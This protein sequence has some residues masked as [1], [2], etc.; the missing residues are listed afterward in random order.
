MIEL[1]IREVA[2]SRGIENPFALQTASGLNYAVCHRLWKAQS[3]MIGI[4]TLDKLCSALDCYPSDLFVYTAQNS[5][6]SEEQA[7]IDKTNKPKRGRRPTKKGG[8]RDNR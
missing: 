7:P 6:P 4:E 3:K 2:E 1:K 8:K 5:A